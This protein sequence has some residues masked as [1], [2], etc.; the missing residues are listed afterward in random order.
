MRAGRVPWWAPCGR[1]SIVSAT[2]VHG[3]FGLLYY[4]VMHLFL[5]FISEHAS[6]IGH[7]CSLTTITFM[8]KQEWCSSVCDRGR[9]DM[10]F[11]IDGRYP[12]QVRFAYATIILHDT[13]YMRCFLG[14]FVPCDKTVLACLTLVHIANNVMASS[15]HT[16]ISWHIY[17]KTMKAVSRPS[18]GC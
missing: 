5:L 11:T 9:R 18:I 1:C 17:D 7:G 14:G 15:M 16:I 13:W 2:I 3:V 10:A 12:R 4:H 6:E 8:S